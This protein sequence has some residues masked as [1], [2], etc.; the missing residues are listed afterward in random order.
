MPLNNPFQEHR[1]K[2]LPMAWLLFFLLIGISGSSCGP[3]VQNS[4]SDTSNLKRHTFH[5]QFSQYRKN[6]AI[7][8][9][10][11]NDLSARKLAMAGYVATSMKYG[12]Q[13][14][15]NILNDKKRLDRIKQR[16][17]DRLEYL[18]AQPDVDPERI[19]A[20]GYSFGGYFATYLATQP[21]E[22]GLRAAVLYYGLFDTPED[23]RNLRA[24]VLAFLGDADTSARIQWSLAMREIAIKHEKQFELVIYRNADHGFEYGSAPGDHFADEDSWKRMI[25]FLDNHVKGK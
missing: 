23:I 9:F 17:I 14:D 20:V 8:I 16:V 6:P 2:K 13:I 11:E 19:G 7:L 3:S 10:P 1:S 25:A 5:P 18:K 4:S 24:P 12:E 15:G 21:E 22:L